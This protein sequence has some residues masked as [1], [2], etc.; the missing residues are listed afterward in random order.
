MFIPNASSSSSSSSFAPPLT[1]AERQRIMPAIER[2][3]ATF[4]RISALEKKVKD[5]ESEIQKLNQ[6]RATFLDVHSNTC[7]AFNSKCSEIQAGMKF[8]ESE[9]KRLQAI[10]DQYSNVFNPLE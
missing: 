7:A 2:A 9:N 3:T 4:E 8:L 10:V 6:E 1:D 5:Q